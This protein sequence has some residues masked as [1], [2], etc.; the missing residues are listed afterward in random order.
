MKFSPQLNLGNNMLKYLRDTFF[1]KKT[2]PKGAFEWDWE[3]YRKDV[4]CYPVKPVPGFPDLAVRMSD[5]EFRPTKA[6]YQLNLD[7]QLARAKREPTAAM[8]H[9]YENLESQLSQIRNQEAQSEKKAEIAK[10]K[11]SEQRF[12]HFSAGW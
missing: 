7:M 3:D 9:E 4:V 11:E 5:E 12:N 2:P 1:C 10:D 8:E 6:M